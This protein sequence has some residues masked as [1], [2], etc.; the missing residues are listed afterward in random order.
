VGA[1]AD[2]V[3]VEIGGRGGGKRPPTRWEGEGRWGGVVM[4]LSPF[5]ALAGLVGCLPA[6]PTPTGGWPAKKTIQ[7]KK[8]KSSVSKK[9]KIKNS[10]SIFLGLEFL[11]L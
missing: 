6:G 10:K 5:S 4:C 1:E 11:G 7:N 2:A 3:V 8:D 9:T